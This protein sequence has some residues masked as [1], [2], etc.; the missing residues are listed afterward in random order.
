MS[1]PQ[2]VHIT[3]L[4][5]PSAGSLCPG[6]QQS[7]TDPPDVFV[8]VVVVV[9]VVACDDALAAV[10]LRRVHACPSTPGVVVTWTGDLLSP[11]DA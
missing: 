1:R 5:D 7:A 11:G 2:P 3:R 6:T 9:V 10:V 4:L 8:V